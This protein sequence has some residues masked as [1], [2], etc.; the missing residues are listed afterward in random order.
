[1]SLRSKVIAA[2]AALGIVGGP[3][4]ADSIIAPPSVAAKITNY[5]ANGGLPELQA[6]RQKVIINSPVTNCKVLIIGDS[7]PAGYGASFDAL[8]SDAR[9]FSWP[10]TLATLLTQ[11]GVKAS[12]AS[13]LGSAN[14]GSISAYTGYDTR[15]NAGAWNLGSC[16]S[17]PCFGGSTGV[18]DNTD[19]TS[20]FS[21]NP[22]DSASFTS[23][24]LSTDTLD[25]IALTYSGA[26]TLSISANGGSTIGSMN[27]NAVNGFLEQ[28]FSTTLGSNVWDLKCSAN[29]TGGCLF[30][31]VRAYN[32]AQSEISILNAGWDGSKT[33]DWVNAGNS[34]WD[35]LSTITKIAPTL[36]IVDLLINDEIAGTATATVSANTQTLITQCKNAGADVLLVTPNPTSPATVS[37]ATQ[38]TY[39]ALYRSLAISN[40]IPLLD[41]FANLCGAT[42]GSTCPNGGWNAGM[43]AGWN[44]SPITTTPD[45][46]HM[47]VAGYTPNF[48]EPIAQVLMQ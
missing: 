7:T 46:A 18:F 20:V 41:V 11:S 30:L 45:V 39:M 43:E 25:V 31:M 26:G 38:Q 40:N 10:S 27:L 4:F 42:S 16:S 37:Y 19:A 9:A 5:T 33:G 8:G 17:G 3:A 6:C 35:P 34:P 14:A 12:A 15:A 24:S 2:V 48:A 44:A 28:T 23:N 29:F 36:C 21:F 13:I 22:A 32:S 1:M 47:S